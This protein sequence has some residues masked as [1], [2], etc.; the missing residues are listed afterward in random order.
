MPGQHGQYTDSL[1]AGRFGDRIPGLAI[2]FAPVQ[3]GP[4]VHLPPM[5]WVNFPSFPKVKRLGRGI[6]LPPPSFPAV[7]QRVE[8]GLFLYSPSF[9]QSF[10][11]CSRNPKNG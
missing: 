9:I 10:L 3:T 11:Y 1:G 4:E 2:F 5:Q 8:L 7:K 6:N